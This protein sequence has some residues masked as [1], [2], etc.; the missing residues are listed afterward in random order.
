[1]TFFED[2]LKKE[3]PLTKQMR[4]YFKRYPES[5][6]L[7]VVLNSSNGSIQMYDGYHTKPGLGVLSASCTDTDTTKTLHFRYAHILACVRKLHKE[8][9]NVIPVIDNKEQSAYRSNILI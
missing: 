1:M 2:L 5:K 3:S 4:G 7:Y 6:Q 8:D 9:Y